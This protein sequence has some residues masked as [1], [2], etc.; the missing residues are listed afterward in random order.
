MYKKQSC[1]VV[2]A[3]YQIRLDIKVSFFS[4]ERDTSTLTQMEYA[5]QIRTT[6]IPVIKMILF[7]MHE[8]SLS[9]HSDGASSMES[10]RDDSEMGLD[11]A[12]IESSCFWDTALGIVVVEAEEARVAIIICLDCVSRERGRAADFVFI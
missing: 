3:N 10:E 2:D 11:A 9:A 5:N 7:A 6:A 4:L 8:G 12:A 1:R